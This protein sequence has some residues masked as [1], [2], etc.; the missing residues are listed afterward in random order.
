MFKEKFD[1]SMVESPCLALIHNL[2][3]YN[4]ESHEKI[5]F[6]TLIS[7]SDS[8]SEL[9][10]QVPTPK[11]LNDLKSVMK[12]AG[13]ENLIECMDDCLIDE[14]NDYPEKEFLEDF[15]LSKDL[16]IREIEKE[17]FGENDPYY[18]N[19]D[20]EPYHLTHL[21][22]D[23]DV[24]EESYTIVFFVPNDKVKVKEFILGRVNALKQKGKSN[25]EIF[26]V[27]HY[28]YLENIIE[29]SDKEAYGQEIFEYI[30]EI[31]PSEI[32]EFFN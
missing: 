2:E 18:F 32:S 7:M 10:K 24:F 6:G 30:H 5:E 15:E 3:F 13:R 16:G 17:L 27:I 19:V 21:I 29:S 14:I 26:K 23:I 1:Y 11:K 4:N 8:F 31:L 25:Y 9:K 28:R 22:K 12:L 20:L